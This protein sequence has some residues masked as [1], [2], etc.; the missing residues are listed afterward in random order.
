MKKWKKFSV[1]LLAMILTLAMTV[2]VSA[3][4]FPIDIGYTDD[5][6]FIQNKGGTEMSGRTVDRD[7]YVGRNADFTFY[8][9]LTVHGNL[10]VLGTFRN[11]GTVN[12]DGN[13][14]CLNY[15]QGNCLLERATQDDGNGNTQCFDNGNFYNYGDISSP[16]Y[17]DANYAF[18]EIPTVWYCT[19]SSVS[20]ATCTK[21]KKCKD[22]GKVL[23]GA[24]GHNWRSAT[25][26]SAKKCSRCGKTAGKALG[27]KWSRWK[28]ANK[29][30]VFKKA[31]QARICSRC[32]RKQIRS[33][34]SKLKPILKFNR[35]NVNMN[36]YGSTNVRVTLANGDRIK[37]ARPQNRSM[38]TVGITNKQINIYGNGKTGKTKILVTLA[39]GKKGYITVTIKKP[40]YTIEDPGDLFE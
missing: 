24:L 15:Y 25:C 33:V 23:S 19:H 21:P 9:E 31:T 8:G 34:G 16:P 18:I 20:K 5:G 38:L 12:V 39:S 13:I 32:K 1:I 40:E 27:H 10:Y 29:A 28:N 6:D 7:M 2:P 14:F 30:T 3:A 36:A 37:S 26:T 4:M 35:R 11:H 17:V 22:C